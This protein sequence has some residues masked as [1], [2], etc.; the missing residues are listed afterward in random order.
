MI[1]RGRLPSDGGEVEELDGG[2]E[3]SKSELDV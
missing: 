2:R 3:D 1:L